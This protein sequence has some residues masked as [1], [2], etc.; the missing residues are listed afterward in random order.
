MR[1]PI[2]HAG[3]GRNWRA[4][5]L[6]LS[7]ENMTYTQVTTA[8]PGREGRRVPGVGVTVSLGPWFWWAEVYW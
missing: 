1:R 7:V 3:H 8:R 6:E 4:F 5:R 2:L